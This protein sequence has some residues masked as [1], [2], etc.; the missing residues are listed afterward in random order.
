M[1][2]LRELGLSSTEKKRLWGDLI[3]AFQKGTGS[4]AES[5]VK[6]QKETVSN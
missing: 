2:S 6:E 5:A 1:T 4:L 3:A